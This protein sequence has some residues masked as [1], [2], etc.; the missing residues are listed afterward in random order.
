MKLLDNKADDFEVCHEPDC[1]FGGT[2]NKGFCR[3]YSSPEIVDP[4]Y[5]AFQAV[6]EKIR[7]KSMRDDS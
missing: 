5:R 7:P 6:A 3:Y 2:H 1:N 4:I